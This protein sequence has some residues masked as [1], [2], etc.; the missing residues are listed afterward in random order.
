MPGQK[1]SAEDAAD[2]RFAARLIE[3]MTAAAGRPLTRKETARAH[4]HV[5]IAREAIDADIR[6]E[7]EHS[8]D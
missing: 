2:Q 4:Q 5:Q 7:L 3:I 6:E 1:T 8:H